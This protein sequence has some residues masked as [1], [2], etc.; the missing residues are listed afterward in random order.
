MTKD[1]EGKGD[2][3]AESEALTSGAQEALMRVLV[4]S[5]DQRV[6]AALVDG[7]MVWIKRYDV[8]Q[9]SLLK[10]LHRVA[11]PLL[12]KSF[13]RASPRV[14][15]S[16]MVDRELRKME[17]FRQA[18]FQVP[19]LLF[20]GE[21]VM[22]LSHVA[23]IVQ[24]EMGR[25]WGNDS[26]AHDNLLVGAAAALAHAHSAGLCHGR[27]HPRD[28]FVSAGRWGFLDFEEEP[29]AVMPLRVAQARDVWLLFMQISAKALLTGTEERA[30]SA[31]AAAGPAGSLTCLATIVDFFSPLLL[32]LAMMEKV[33]LG[34]D[35]RRLLKATRFL[36]RV[37]AA[38]GADNAGSNTPNAMRLGSAEGLKEGP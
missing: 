26:E 27:P 8:A 24:N 22:V 23:D 29:E 32:P 30:F 36:R 5:H 14:D 33:A 15:A 17:A 4:S 34:N 28:M 35:L 11:E 18:G 3:A 20:R 31:Y 38:R 2:E 10:R 19:E 7:R 12:P 25:L 1:E 9:R 6:S 13:M 16:G 37:L 21:K